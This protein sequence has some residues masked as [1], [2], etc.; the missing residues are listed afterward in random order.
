MAATTLRH[1]SAGRRQ[2][3]SRA[4]KVN[5][6]QVVAR[7]LAAPQYELVP[8]HGAI[9]ESRQLP[10]GATVT[11]TSSPARG[12]EATVAL[13]EALSMYGLRTVPH[14]A[15]RQ[16]TD[17]AQLADVCR[18]LDEAGI[19]DVFVIGGD[20]TEPAGEFADG[21]ALLQALDR[22]GQRL[23]SIGIPGYPEGHHLIDDDTLWTSLEAKASY[24]TYVVTQMCFDPDA[25]CRYARAVRDAGIDLPVYAGVPGAVDAAKLLRISMQI[26]VGDSLR[27]VRNNAAVARRLL[28]PVGYRPDS[29]VKK[30]AARVADGRC[31]IA[32]LHLYT[33]NQVGATVGWVHQS[34]RGGG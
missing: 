3:K 6:R 29:L 17:E 1:K 22:I 31:D 33:F 19:T 23:T 10:G 26:G 2:R 32:G 4:G 9:D 25:T 7:W 13:A 5:T 34:S 21:L 20:A 8:L 28:R 24:A 27:F 16:I 18:R 14:L 11:I 12:V 30:L 15:A